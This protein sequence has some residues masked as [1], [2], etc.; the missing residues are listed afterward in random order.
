MGFLIPLLLQG[1]TPV[2]LSLTTVIN[3]VLHPVL[4]IWIR[5]PAVLMLESGY[6]KDEILRTKERER[7]RE[8][9]GIG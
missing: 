5:S 4:N 3:R 6:N 2:L 1:K 7:E 9:M 8:G